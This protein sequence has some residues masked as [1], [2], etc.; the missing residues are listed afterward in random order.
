M[1]TPP[2]RRAVKHDSM[3]LKLGRWSPQPMARLQPLRGLFLPAEYLV[4]IAPSSLTVRTCDWMQAVAL[5]LPSPFRLCPA[6]PLRLPHPFFDQR[7]VL[8]LFAFARLV[9]VRVT[10]FNEPEVGVLR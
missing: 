4:P 6:R 10:R 3:K 2:V 1:K 5:R 8:R 7:A 9:V